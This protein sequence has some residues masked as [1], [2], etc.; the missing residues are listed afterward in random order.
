MKILIF[1]DS[2]T[3]WNSDNLEWGWANILKFNLLKNNSE[4]KVAN[5]WI[6]WDE[7]PDILNRFE[8]STKSYIDKY[9]KVP[10][11]I[12]AVWINDSVTNINETNN[13][14]SEKEFEENLEKLYFLAK[15][16]NPEKIVF[17]W[18][19]NVNEKLVCPT[20]YWDFWFCYKNNRIQK[21]DKIIKNISENNNCTYI[22]MYNLLKN[23]DMPDWLHPNNIWHKKMFNK[24][25]D[26]LK[27]FE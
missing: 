23:E 21:F 7:V 13:S 8:I 17:I 2:I 24:I 1:W 26:T 22:E 27:E 20:S 9:E 19:T 6:W 11:F 18:L 25:I 3:E 5:L 16:Y 14:Y 10:Y 15:E 4:I 12:F